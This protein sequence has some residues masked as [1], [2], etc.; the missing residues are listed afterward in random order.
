MAIPC[1]AAERGVI[2]AIIEPHQ[3]RLL[4]RQSLRSAGQAD[5]PRAAQA[6]P[7][8][9]LSRLDQAEDIQPT[10][11]TALDGWG[12]RSIRPW[13]RALGR[14]RWFAGCPICSQH[15][16][17]F[18]ARHG[19]VAAAGITEVVVLPLLPNSCRP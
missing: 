5:Q 6:R 9:D 14:L 3:P 12:G 1:I 4:L 7:D 16:D 2:D 13:Y 17:T 11:F 10:A 19:D 8:P 15:L 18:A